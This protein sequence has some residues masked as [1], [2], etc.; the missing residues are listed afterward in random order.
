MITAQALSFVSVFFL[1]FCFWAIPFALGAF[2]MLQVVWCCKMSRC[3]IITAG[4]FAAIAGVLSTVKGI[5]VIVSGTTFSCSTDDDYSEYYVDDADDDACKNAVIVASSFALSGGLLW[6]ATAICTFVFVCGSRIRKFDT[7][8]DDEEED[9]KTP[10]AIAVHVNTESQPRQK[11]RSK[12][13]RSISAVERGD[14]DK[15]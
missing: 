5:L 15:N 11:K 8:N 14:S 1:W 6:I 9:E 12:K 4:V 2:I 7:L 10:H 13:S 3:G